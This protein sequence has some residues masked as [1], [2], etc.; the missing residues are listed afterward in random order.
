MKNDFFFKKKQQL[1]FAL[2]IFT[3][4]LVSHK[5]SDQNLISLNFGEL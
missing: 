3:N 4:L 1:K 5:K 2:E